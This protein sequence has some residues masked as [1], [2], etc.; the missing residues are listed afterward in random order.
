[1]LFGDRVSKG[2]LQNACDS[3]SLLKN[4]RAYDEVLNSGRDIGANIVAG[5]DDNK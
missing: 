3:R 2:V 5:K 1:M 4:D